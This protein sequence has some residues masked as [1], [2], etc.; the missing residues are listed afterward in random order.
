MKRKICR[1][2]QRTCLW[3]S[4]LGRTL[5]NNK[6]ILGGGIRICWADNAH[7]ACINLIACSFRNRRC[8][9]VRLCV[10][11][12]NSAWECVVPEFCKTDHF[13][14]TSCDA[15]TTSL[16]QLHVQLNEVA[17]VLPLGPFAQSTKKMDFAH[18]S[19]VRG[20]DYKRKWSPVG[21]VT[22]YRY[23]R[24]L[25]SYMRGTLRIVSLKSSG[26]WIV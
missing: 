21:G 12:F 26:M 8:L 25:S 9:L 10:K 19:S 11:I 24:R 2:S 3:L 4:K 1:W 18:L 5:N 15:I 16:A 23:G 20:T 22:G 6:I 13:K 14:A 7:P 17:D